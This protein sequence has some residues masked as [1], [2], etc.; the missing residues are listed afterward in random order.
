MREQARRSPLRRPDAIVVVLMIVVA[1]VNTLFTYLPEIS[2]YPPKISLATVKVAADTPRYPTNVAPIQTLP[3]VE[4]NTWDSSYD[5]LVRKAAALT[6]IAPT[7]N[8]DVA[9]EDA[10]AGPTAVTPTATANVA[11]TMASDGLASSDL[12]GDTKD[13]LKRGAASYRDGAFSTAIADFNVAIEIDPN[14][15]DAYI[16]R[17][18]TWYR[19]GNFDR[20]FA[21]VAQAIRIQNS[22]QIANPPLPKASPS[23]SKN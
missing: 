8:Y 16:D 3:P 7:A 19:I 15:E 13:Y 23:L 14:F 5:K 21:D 20:A 22:H 18:I 17:G 12:F 9:G 11:E 10:P 1:W 2:A 6:T 4:L